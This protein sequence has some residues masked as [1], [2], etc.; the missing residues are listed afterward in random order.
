MGHVVSI[1]GIA[2]DPRK[3]EAVRQFPVPENI[4]TLR[5]FL[6]LASY[7][8]RFVPGFSAV[9]SPLFALTR[10]DA[11]F[12]WTR[13]CEEALEKLKELMTE[14]PLLSFPDFSRDFLLE[15]DASGEGLGAVLVQ[16]S[17][18]GAVHPIAYASR[19]LQPSERNYG[20]TELE[21]LGVVWAVKHFHPYIYG[22]RCEVFTDHEALKSLLHTPHPSGKLARWGLALQ[23]LDLEIRYRPL[24]KNGNADDLSRSPVAGSLMAT[25]QPEVV[26]AATVPLA[27]A[28]GGETTLEGK[29]QLDPSLKKIMDYMLH[30]VLPPEDRI[31]RELVLSKS[32]YQW[33]SVPNP[34][35]PNPLDHSPHCGLQGIVSGGT[36]RHIWWASA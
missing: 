17:E 24:R 6:G 20:V 30:K 10:K 7:Y 34:A 25:D 36:C 26:V 23:E 22:H 28:K 35:G 8:R 4:K 27:E 5:S 2:P 21:T 19:T 13:S 1:D 3:V 16:R 11:P 14:A 12:L 29:Q 9:A 31:A 15:T 33:Y 18:S 32:Q